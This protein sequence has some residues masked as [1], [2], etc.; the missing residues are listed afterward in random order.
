MLK[1]VQASRLFWPTVILVLTLVLLACTSTEFVRYSNGR[2][3]GSLID[4]FNRGSQVMLLALGMALV[5]GT[6]GVDLSVGAVM[7]ISGAMGAML[8]TQHNA[9]LAVTV[10][11]ALGVGLLC[12]LWNGLLVAKFEIQP[13]VATLILMVAGR[14]VAQLLTDGEI[15][16]FS[17]PSF[18]YIGTG[19]LVGVP[20]TVVLVVAMLALVG[21]LCDRTQLRLFIESVGNNAVA[22]RA[23][24]LPVSRVRLL[25]Y[26]VSGLCAGLA[27][28]IDTANIK[29]ADA[30]NAGL[31]LEL[32][33]ILAVVIGGTSLDGGRF[34]LIGAIL[35]ALIVQALTTTILTSHVSVHATRVVKALVVVAVCL[36][37]SPVFRQKLA[38]LVGGRR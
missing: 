13:I 18:E 25:V 31:Y 34:S 17:N 36:M 1:R 2:L 20:F 19:Y 9:P 12:G 24:G 15:L 11:A 14:G 4:V 22:S 37:Q 30:N 5:I 27:G 33:A 38:R 6:G 10:P 35:G 23:A 29:A 16:T 26:M 7:A 21:T 8:L 32:D 28:L 3:H